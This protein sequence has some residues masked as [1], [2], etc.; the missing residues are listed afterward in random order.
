MVKD[1]G[2]SEWHRKYFSHECNGKFYVFAGGATEWSNVGM[3]PLE[4][5]ECRRPTPEE[6]EPKTKP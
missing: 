2:E 3:D 4:W 1:K 5:D 6:L